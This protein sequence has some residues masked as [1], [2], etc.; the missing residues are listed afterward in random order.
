M[1]YAVALTQ[2]LRAF[3]K[4]LERTPL[5]AGYYNDIAALESLMAK[6]NAGA[7][8]PCGNS[9]ALTGQAGASV[10]QANAIPNAADESPNQRTNE[11]PDLSPGG[12]KAAPDTR[13]HIAPAT[14]PDCHET[15]RSTETYPEAIKRAIDTGETVTLTPEQGRQ[16]YADI[17]AERLQSG[18]KACPC[19]GT[20]DCGR[21][22]CPF[23]PLDDLPEPPQVG[24]KSD[25]ERERIARFQASLD[26]EIDP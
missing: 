23:Q 7:G 1:E 15:G 20:E 17:R 10:P 3:I 22:V 14:H 21:E 5:P 9:A 18:K 2:G 13:Q 12:C 25:A 24:T 19:G 26:E 11:G 16:L 6:F 8:A 4:R